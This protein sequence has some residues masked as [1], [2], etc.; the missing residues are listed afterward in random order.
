[1]STDEKKR[2]IPTANASPMLNAY[3]DSIGGTLGD[4]A[5]FL[6]T[7]QLD[8]VFQSFYI[9]PSIFNTD[10]DR[11]FSVIDYGLN[12][13]YASQDDLK[14]LNRLGITLKFDV[15]LNHSS[16]LSKQFQDILKNGERSKYKDFFINWNTFWAGCG[17]MTEEG[18]IEPTPDYLK[19]MFFRKPGLPILMVRMP[20]GTE[21][22]YWNTFYQ[23]VKYG[24]VDAQDLMRVADIQYASAEKLAETVNQAI[25]KGK[26]PSE[27]EFGRFARYRDKVID[28]LE[29]RRKYLGQ[30]DLN[31]KS[32]LVW[33]FYEETLRKLAG[34]GAKIIRL[35]AFAYAPKEPGSRNFLNDPGTW[36][37][38]SRVRIL[39]DKC[40]LTLLPEIHSRYEEKIHE[41]LAQKGYMTYDFFLP[42]LI[43]DALER[44]TGEFLVKWIKDMREKNIRVVNMLGCHDGIPLLDLK[45]LL[46]DEQIQKL[47][48]IVV[49]RGGYVKDLHGNKNMYYQV[50]ATYY[51]ALGEDDAKLLLARA[52]QIFMPGK[53]QVWYLDLL[54]GKNDHAAVAKAGPGGHKEINRTNL[55]LEQARKALEKDVVAKQL[56]LLKFRSECPAF[57]FDSKLEILD[58]RPEVLKLRWENMGCAATL[59][60]NLKDYSFKISA[61]DE[62]GKQT[63][64]FKA[65]GRFVQTGFPEPTGRRVAAG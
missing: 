1:M 23:E 17:K 36:E 54:A 64:H 47:I 27:I 49:Q 21:V 7:P 62:T 46:S 55:T 4:I 2:P 8:G 33:E 61:T 18:Y 42:G 35:D 43:I 11:G 32:P 15:V 50:N 56:S 63:Y 58:S 52:I 20:E 53:P 44:N 14:N 5:A 38:L 16:V 30:M 9:L 39:A 10:L 31:I 65:N 51:S 57:G 6:Q 40:G 48:D 24:Q 22:P 60:A 59:E 13:I 41:T 26:T 29:S 19:D 12:E 45:G 37:L 34:Y 3:P 28:L 25:A